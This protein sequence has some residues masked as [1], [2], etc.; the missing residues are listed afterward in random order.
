VPAR[1]YDLVAEVLLAAAS[2]QKQGEP[3][4]AAARRAARARGAQLAEEAK[5]DR[6]S[7]PRRRLEAL[8][9]ALGYT[10][11]REGR[12]VVLRNC[13]F[14]RLRE[15]DLNLVCGINHALAQGYVDGSG[16]ADAFTAELRPCPDNCCVVL[17]P[18]P[19]R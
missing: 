11:A 16:A 5:P 10:P 18:R 17:A 9:G 2:A 8:L 19:A 13:P 12:E 6:R 3:F 14:D 4:E 15:T 1:R 7:G